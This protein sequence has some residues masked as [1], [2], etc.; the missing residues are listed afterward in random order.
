MGNLTK[1]NYLHRIFGALKNGGAEARM[2]ILIHLLSP[3]TQLLDEI[4]EN[5][6]DEVFDNAKGIII[7]GP[8]RSGST[9][10]YQAITCA[11]PCLPYTNLHVLFPNHATSYIRKGKVKNP[12]KK[13][14]FNNYNGYTAG[15]LD[16]N[17]GN[18]IFSWAHKSENSDFLKRN[19]EKILS[20]MNPNPDEILVLKNNLAYN[21]I[22]RIYEAT[23]GKKFIFIRIQRDLQAV[24][25]S[26]LKVY[27]ETKHFQPIPESLRSSEITD[28]VEFACQQ[29]LS[30]DSILEDQFN[31]IP[32]QSKFV[33]EYEDFCQKPY[34][35]M[36]IL[37]HQYLGL[38]KG[39]VIKCPA[40]DS[41]KES[42]RVKVT[43]NESKRISEF[44]KTNNKFTVN[45]YY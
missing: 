7:C 36:E 30:I 5:K 41:I 13:V 25:E 9:L 31:K 42:S 11:L 1:D 40:L 44:L 32:E 12:G 24:I 14:R 2:G 37:A 8:P 15:L 3:F 39:S 16:V 10:I 28:P 38:E 33:I 34:D 17:E 29:I 27:A 45:N 19:F 4:F 6:F 23:N 21:V 20:E 35:Y 26:V 18:N 43:T 22:D